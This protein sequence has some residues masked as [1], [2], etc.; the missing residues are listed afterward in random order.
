MISLQSDT[1]AAWRGLTRIAARRTSIV[2]TTVGTAESSLRRSLGCI[3]YL[4]HSSPFPNAPAVE[5]TSPVGTRKTNKLRHRDVLGSETDRRSLPC[6]LKVVQR[7]LS[8]TPPESEFHLP[9]APLS[10]RSSVRSVSS[11]HLAFLS[12]SSSLFLCLSFEEPSP[13]HPKKLLSFFLFAGGLSGAR[14]RWCASAKGTT[15]SGGGWV[16]AG[17]LGIERGD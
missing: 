13:N 3:P 17:G 16:G 10:V 12:L 5:V 14:D 9:L 15:G 2:G 6:R 11:L 8:P 1:P 4:L 7:M